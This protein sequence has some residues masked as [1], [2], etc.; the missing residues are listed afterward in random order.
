MKFG[1]ITI[2]PE[3]FYSCFNFGIIK[4]AIKNKKIIIDLW[5]L[6]NFSNKKKIDDKIYGGGPGVL[7]KPKP[8]YLAICNAKNIYNNKFCIIYLSPQGIILN[9]NI[10]EKLFLY[11]KLILICGRYNGIDQRIIDNYVDMELSIGDYVLSCGEIPS[12]V[13]IDVLVRQIPGI[14]NNIDSVNLDSFSNVKGI[15]GYPN[16]TKPKNFNGFCVPDVLLS[17]NH[18]NIKK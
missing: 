2:N 9:N 8:L 18:Y 15:L 6:K 5:D 10:I 16:Y 4:K 14:L 1:I 11:E 12:L 3:F 13:L 7:I 17:G